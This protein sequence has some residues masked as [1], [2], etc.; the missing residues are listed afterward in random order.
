MQDI[1]LTKSDY[2]DYQHCAKSLWLRKHK[3]EVIDWPAPD[4]FDRLLMQDGYKVEALVKQ[5]V[6]GWHHS[7]H[8]IFQ[9]EFKSTDGLFARADLVRRYD[10]GQIDIFEIKASTSIAGDSGQDHVEDAAFQTLVAER[11]GATVK[12][13]HIIHV[14]K[15]YMRAGAINLEELLTIVDITEEVRNR[16]GEVAATANEALAF[17]NQ[18]KI[19][20]TGCACAF[21]GSQKKQCASFE[22]FNPNIPDTSVYLLPRVSRKKLEVFVGDGRLALSDIGEDE[23]TATQL[24]VLQSAKTGAPIINKDKIAAF[25]ETL[26]WPLHF[27]DYETFKSAI[28]IADGIS[29]QQATPVQFSHHL[30]H[31]D[32]RLEHYEFLSDKPGQQ[33]ELVDALEASFEPSGSVI[34]WNKSFEMTCNRKLSAYLT[35][36]ASFLED[37]NDRTV[38][39]QDPFK[40]DYVDIRFQGSTSIKKV[41]PIVCPHLSYNEDAVHD[42][43]GAMAAWLTYIETSD[44]A[45]RGRLRSELLAYCKLDTLA[46]V[47]IYSFLRSIE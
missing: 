35:D 15:S 45:E 4:P 29:P 23:V 42:G 28:P 13:V 32:G 41:L 46:M 36:K 21:V 18:A 30:L 8:C 14:N 6:A 27:Y 2:L 44:D 7:E 1:V 3:P 22:Y 5:M 43:A 17:L 10:E 11:C 47:E 26:S 12:S 37:V 40:R 25:L 33:R 24:P 38:D 9:Q 20:E 31:Q 16:L 34:S 39:L 19:D